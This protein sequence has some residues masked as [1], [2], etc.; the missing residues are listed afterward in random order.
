MEKIV[1]ICFSAEIGINPFVQSVK[2]ESDIVEHVKYV[3]QCVY[4]DDGPVY[5]EVY[6]MCDDD[7]LSFYRCFTY[8]GESLRKCFVLKPSSRYV[9]NFV[10]DYSLNSLKL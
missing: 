1:I 5:A 10:E 4:K 2:D 7:L 9:K 6:R 3:V 8:D